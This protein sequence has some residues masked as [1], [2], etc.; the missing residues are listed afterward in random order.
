MYAIESIINTN[1]CINA[2]NN[3][4]NIAGIGSP[5]AQM[6]NKAEIS[7]SPAKIFAKSLKHKLK[8]LVTI[9]RILTN[10]I[11][12]PS[13]EKPFQTE[14]IPLALKPWNK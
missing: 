2:T 7:I 13:R 3:S 5:I 9:S 14:C 4:K 11:I 6:P 8:G 10:V 12:I 1:A